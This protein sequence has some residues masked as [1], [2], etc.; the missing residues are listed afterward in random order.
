M[1]ER[2][3]LKKKPR[4]ACAARG[5]TASIGRRYYSAATLWECEPSV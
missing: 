1:W 3:A 4:A 2:G 5:L